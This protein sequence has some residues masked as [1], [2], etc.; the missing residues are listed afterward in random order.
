MMALADHFNRWFYL[1]APQ[2]WCRFRGA[3]L[4]MVT[5]RAILDQEA[6]QGKKRMPRLQS[7][8]IFLYT[9]SLPPKEQPIRIQIVRG[10]ET[11]NADADLALVREKDDE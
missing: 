8:L 11:G 7:A 9:L 2:L 4:M 1:R 5:A 10:G 3:R 6:A